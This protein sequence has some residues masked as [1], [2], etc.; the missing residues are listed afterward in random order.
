M[1]RLHR[2]A[3]GAT[4]AALA[5][6]ALSTASCTQSLFG[7]KVDNGESGVAVPDSFVVA[8]ETSRGQFN[9]LARKSWAPRGVS[10]FYALLEDKHYD[11]NRF[12]RVVKGFVAQFGL[13][14][15]PKVN[16]TWKNRCIA[17]EPVRHPNTRGTVAFAR[18][19]PNSRSVQLFV[20]LVDNRKLDTLSGF[21]FPP[22]AEVDSG[23]D[24]VD[25]LY[26]GYGEA[27]PRSGSEYGMEGPS[28][29]SIMS[30]GNAYLNAGWPKLDY[31]KT[32]RIVKSWP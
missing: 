4:F 6:L 3:K 8:F 31:V 21:G 17:D 2:T 13:S 14:G 10:R 11:D 26:S 19:G 1:T 18:G 7:C 30:R 24:V 28:Q 27:A 15:D 22:I 23:M 32:A 5:A 12:F 20:N 9:V 29:D 16:D 25:S